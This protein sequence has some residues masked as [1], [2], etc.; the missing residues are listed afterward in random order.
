MKL[1]L[2]NNADAQYKNKASIYKFIPCLYIKTTFTFTLQY[3]K[4]ALDFA[5][6]FNRKVKF[7]LQTS[8]WLLMYLCVCNLKGIITA[9]E[10]YMKAKSE[11]P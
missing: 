5:V 10:S 3:G 6:T 9:L 11:E 4:T 1:L 8:T 2:K 7:I